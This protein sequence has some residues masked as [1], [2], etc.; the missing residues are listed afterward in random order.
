MP[1]SRDKHIREQKA[2][3]FEAA[4]AALAH[5]NLESGSLGWLGYSSNAVFQLEADEGRYV[6]R[7]QRNGRV[8]EARLRAELQWLRLIGQRTDLRVPQPIP[9]VGAEDRGELFVELTQGLPP[10]DETIYCTLFEYL[11]GESRPAQDLTSEDVYRIGRFLARL[12]SEAQFEPPPGF[13]RPRLD[14]QGLFG[15]DSPYHSPGAE[16]ALAASQS[17]V[18]AAVAE[19]ARETMRRLADCADSFGLIHADLLAKNIVFQADALAALDFEYCGWGCYL[20]DLT[21]L[22]WQLKGD[23][24]AD[25]PELEAALW[26]GYTSIRAPAAAKRGCLETLI[27]ARQLASCR[28]LLAHRHHAAI[29]SQAPALL[30]ERCAE[31]Q[32]FLE[33]GILQRSSKTL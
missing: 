20:Y 19:R 3:W 9:V 16:D 27:A 12:H 32:G 24:A 31:L 14:W 33:T 15:A 17:A 22:L 18:F 2:R 13:D 23:R 25:Y 7:L 4:T 11:A 1:L 26:A 21:P 30:A 10:A 6:L 29:G 5:W 28:W 8:Y